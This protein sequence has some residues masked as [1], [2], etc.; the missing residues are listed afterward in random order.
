MELSCIC[1]SD[2]RRLNK[3]RT[4]IIL[5]ILRKSDRDEKEP[6]RVRVALT[7]KKNKSSYTTL[8]LETLE[9]SGKI[10]FEVILL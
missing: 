8:A 10:F 5:M 6:K 7:K 2:G 1:I 9:D 3:F 4:Y